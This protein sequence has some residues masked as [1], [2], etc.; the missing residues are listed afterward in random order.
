M[1]FIR[2]N[3]ETAMNLLMLLTLGTLWGSTYLFIKI[4]VAEV[5]ALTLVAGQLTLA[6]I[7]MWPVLYW[8]GLALPRE[9]RLW[10]A[11]FVLGLINA[12]IPYTLTSWGEQYIP[13]GLASLL[14]ATMPIFT[15]F[16]AHL[17]VYD[18]RASST[19][20]AG[21]TVGFL[22]VGVLLLPDIQRGLQ[23]GI[24]GQLAVTGS[25]LSY[26]GAA[27]FTRRLLYRQSPWVSAAG[28]MTAGA[29]I[30]LPLSLFIDRPFSLSLPLPVVASWISLALLGTVLAY[31][32]YFALIER[33]SATYLSM[34][35]Y[36]TPVS[37]LLLG[38]VVLNEPLSGAVRVSLIL[39]LM[40]V[41][42]VRI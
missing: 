10:R 28:Q 3:R 16:L 17:F 39:I 9:W 5:P 41:M 35:S 36:I 40:G 31:I 13:S 21:V 29:A 1:N 22:G 8:R 11:Y 23:T 4:T 42:L 33:T 2:R 14:T 34:A 37:G 25:V 24:I 7:F 19:R 38:A 32:I 20:L 18:E 27:V 12:A 30:M 26:S 15:V 6:T